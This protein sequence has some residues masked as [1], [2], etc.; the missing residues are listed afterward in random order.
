[1][2]TI[3]TDYLN[4]QIRWNTLS[5]FIVIFCMTFP[6]PVVPSCT[7]EAK[8]D[9]VFLVDGTYTVGIATFNVI[10]AQIK[11]LVNE[12]EIGPDDVQ[13]AVAVYSRVLNDQFQLN[14]HLTKTELFAAIDGLSY[15]AGL[16]NTGNVLTET[17]TTKFT[18]SAGRRENVPAITVVFADGTSAGLDG[19]AASL[20]VV[21]TVIALGFGGALVDTDVIATGPEYSNRVYDASE[22]SALFNFTADLICEMGN[23]SN[24]L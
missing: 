12:Y 1:M 17:A 9:L 23:I 8:M 15:P 11:D 24:T 6:S 18:P 10:M 16:T 22:I 2:V 14:D 5:L 4:I 19:P 13:V 7:T 20:Q 3:E 21:S